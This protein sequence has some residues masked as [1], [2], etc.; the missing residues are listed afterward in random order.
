MLIFPSLNHQDLIL[1][2]IHGL[3]TLLNWWYLATFRETWRTSIL[4][5]HAALPRKKSPV[6][7]EQFVL[8]L[9]TLQRF[10]KNGWCDLGTPEKSRPHGE[11]H[12]VPGGFSGARHLVPKKGG[13]EKRDPF[14]LGGIKRHANAVVNFTRFPLSKSVLFR[15]ICHII[16]RCSTTTPPLLPPHQ[17]LIPTLLT[18]FFLGKALQLG[19]DA[20]F[21]QQ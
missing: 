8:K 12:Q 1:C 14:F 11:K 17:L 15:F 5:N 7:G 19:G 18:V 3:W 2:L 10:N 6:Q 13:H 4:K 16:T 9:L 21:G 20:L